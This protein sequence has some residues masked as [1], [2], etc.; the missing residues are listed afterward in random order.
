MKFENKAK[1][2]NKRKM[3]R[4]QKSR[5]KCSNLN[6]YNFLSVL[7]LSEESGRGSMGEQLPT[8]GRHNFFYFLFF[9]LFLVMQ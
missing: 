3:N 5:K 1:M 9:V 8:G 2:E 7:K 6:M 4:A